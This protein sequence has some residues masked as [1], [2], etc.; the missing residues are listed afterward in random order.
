MTGR[1]RAADTRCADASRQREAS[2]DTPVTA[3]ATMATSAT[4]SGTATSAVIETS[5]QRQRIIA[6]GA[7]N[8]DREE[9]TEIS[10][11]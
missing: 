6:A 10:T 8:A 4:A 1:P 9:R 2:I 5:N 7:L 11:R 3:K